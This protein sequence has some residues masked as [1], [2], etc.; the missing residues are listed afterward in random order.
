[1]LP[2]L[3]DPKVSSKIS[4]INN[5]IDKVDVLIIGGGMAYTFAK[6]AGGTVGDISL[7]EDGL[8]GLCKQN[9]RKAAKGV[10]LLLPVDNGVA[11]TFSNDANTQVVPAGQI[12]DGWE[13]LDIGPETAKLF[14]DAVKTAKTV[15]WN[16]PMGCFRDAETSRQEPKQLQQHLLKQMQLRSS[17]AEIPQQL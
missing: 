16:G 11:D 17:A 2:S 12:P 6:A 5:L 7:L 15:V 9:E 14:A 3:A 10:K 4:V 13:G 1:M 8:S